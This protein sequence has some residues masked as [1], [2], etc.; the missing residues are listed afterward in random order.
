MKSQNVAVLW[1]DPGMR[2]TSITLKAFDDLKKDNPGITM[3]VIAPL[4]VCRLVWRQEG[5]KWSEF[6]HLKFS[7]LHGSKKLDALKAKADIYLINPEGVPWLAQQFFGRP[8]PFDIVTF[9][10]LTKFKNHAAVR[11]KVLR[12]RIKA[13]S[14]F[15][16]LT[17]SP[18]PN[19]YMD[20]F[21]QF[22]ILDGGAALGRYITQ[23]R[24]TYF[25][26][27]FNGFDY[28]LQPGGAKRIEARIEPYVF[29][30]N[31][32]DYLDLP[33]LI[34]DPRMIEM[35]T[36]SRALYKKMK[37]EMLAELPGGVVTAANSAAAYSKLAQ[38]ANGAVYIGG[39]ASGPR[40]VEI[41]H[42]AKLDALEELIEELDG[43]QLLVAY[44][45][46]HDL[47]RIRTRLGDKTPVLGDGTGARE[48]AE[49]MRRWNAGEI[50]VLLAHPASVGH[51]LNLQESNACHVCWF[52]T[53]WDLELFDQFNRRLKRS[54]NQA[55]RIMMHLLMV[56]DTIDELKLL[57]LNEKDVTQQRL[58]ASLNTI[59]RD[60]DSPAAGLAAPKETTMGMKL[61]RQTAAEE[62]DE[63]P[64]AKVTPKGWGKPAPAAEEADED[65]AEDVAPQ[66]AAI[67]SKIA[68]PP[69]E[70]DEEEDEEEP[71]LPKTCFSTTTKAALKAAPPSELD[72][73]PE[74]A[75][76]DAV[77]GN[78]YVGATPAPAPWDHERYI[79]I[80]LDVPA[81]LYP[82]VLAAI[83][84]A[85]LA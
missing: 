2:K 55:A 36:A 17:G 76:Q 69:A 10:E 65:E 49:I 66:K 25:Q 35:P 72:E 11:S 77:L 15:W 29:S 81:R 16:G 6:R 4:R 34:P 41:V 83:A 75:K 62:E 59:L 38:M 23:Y 21:G 58:R 30:L 8:V 26:P 64:K 3:L 74:F 32:D 33:P 24:D 52:S 68:P 84:K 12:P 46:K 45:F 40:K 13:C 28:V 70:P 71:A 57:A 47:M 80:H 37:N 61:S 60:G 31:A 51:G 82:Q 7:L 14:V 27:D 53:T 18:N 85:L 78:T 56:K 5:E 79:G 42:D 9:D 39:D 20:L 22:F 19:G 73:Q 67:K 1:L 50:P 54:G 63:A 44:E 43:K 48:E